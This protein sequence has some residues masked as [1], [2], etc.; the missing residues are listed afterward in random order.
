MAEKPLLEMSETPVLSGSNTLQLGPGQR[1][2]R[3]LTEPVFVPSSAGQM[4][5]F[6]ML[7]STV[8][9]L[10]QEVFGDTNMVFLS[11]APPKIIQ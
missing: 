6:F 7:R 3:L 10:G 11:A 4:R 9:V 8:P 2:S 1:L 5:G